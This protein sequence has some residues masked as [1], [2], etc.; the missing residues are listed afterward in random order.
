MREVPEGVATY[1]LVAHFREKH[2]GVTQEILM[3]VLSRH[4][5]SLDRQIKEFLNI[6]K[7]SRNPDECLNLKSVW[8]EQNS[9]IYRFPHSKGQAKE[10][11]EP[12]RWRKK[13]T[14]I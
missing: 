6:I 12:D 3:R 13:E 11:I 9:Q 5:T 7:A 2:G 1:P 4:L 10:K 14:R 8:G